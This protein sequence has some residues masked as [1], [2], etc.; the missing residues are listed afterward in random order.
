MTPNANMLII[1]MQ[2]SQFCWIHEWIKLDRL[3]A[4]F[5]SLKPTAHVNHSSVDSWISPNRILLVKGTR[6]YLC[7]L[8]KWL[9]F[10]HADHIHLTATTSSDQKFCPWLSRLP[11][12]QTDGD[13]VLTHFSALYIVSNLWIQPRNSVYRRKL[14]PSPGSVKIPIIS[15]STHSSPISSPITKRII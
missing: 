13:G 10:S 2:Y 4:L 14:V 15:S 6:A 9:Q 8:I 12:T 7:S 5:L 3:D 11:R 1:M